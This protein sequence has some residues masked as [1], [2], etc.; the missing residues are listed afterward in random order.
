MFAGIGG[1]ELGLH[2]AG[3][4]TLELC[5]IDN[6]ARAVLA[7]RFPDIKV[8]EDA[9]KY[10]RV[11]TD[12]DLI[13]AGFPCQD[14]S[15]AGRTLGIRGSRSALVGEVFRLLRT[16]KHDVPLVLLENVPFMLQLARGEALS[17]LVDNLEELGY[18]WA[19]RVVDSRS[20]GLPQ[21]R[22]RVYFLASRSIDPRDVLLADDA[23]EDRSNSENGRNVACGFFWTEG[24]RGLGWAVNA[25]PTL[26]GGSTIGI[27]S[28]PAIV[29]P[30]GDVVTPGIRN[31]ERL[32]GFPADWT[33][34]AE[35]VARPGMRWKLVGN[36]VN[37]RVA[38]WIGRRLAKPGRYTPSL[39]DRAIKP[40]GPWP[41]A[42][43][44]VAGQRFAADVSAW[45]VRRVYQDL[46]E[47]LEQDGLKPLSLKATRGF[48]A[49]FEASTL[50]R[51]SGFVRALRR[52]IKLMEAAERSA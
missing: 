28:P 47:F 37:V 43:Y 17:V 29:M 11:P 31:A 8:A 24:T 6:P 2:R 18:E 52:H 4:K 36:A 21:R 48:L 50:S 35:R 40:H 49:R 13:A 7:R 30:N 15:Q 26:K 39:H 42:A 51:P 12:T 16:T 45:P 27:P 44:S 34:P 20:F 46:A 1:I 22:E 41:K 38:E 23:H 3:H 32:Q 9:T 5:E 19:Y 25:V 10:N 14:L 33:L